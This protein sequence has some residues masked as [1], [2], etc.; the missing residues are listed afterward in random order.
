MNGDGSFQF[1]FG[2]H[3]L[4]Y[5]SQNCHLQEK[6]RSA[7]LWN[8]FIPLEADPEVKYGAGLTNVEYA[9]LCEVMGKSVYGP[10]VCDKS[11]KQPQ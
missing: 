3:C 10:E 8:L 11:E 6:A 5:E 2:I 9:Y 1:V 7:G 4:Q